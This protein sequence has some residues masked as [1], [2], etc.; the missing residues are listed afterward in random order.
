MFFNYLK[1]G[2][3]AIFKQKLFSAINV[4]GLSFS[5]SI[6]MVIIMLLADQYSY[7]RFNTNHDH[8][9]QVNIER[10][11]EPILKG[12]ATSPLP[13]GPKMKEEHSQ[14]LEYARFIRG[15]GNLHLFC[16]FNGNFFLSRI[17]RCFLFS[18]QLDAVCQLDNRFVSGLENL[19]FVGEFNS[20]FILKRIRNVF[21]F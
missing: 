19:H 7:D 14:V 5:L 1:T 17:N 10:F 6:C 12:M 20:D 9:Y 16:K 13:L 21:I 18:Y 15:F 3:R 8:I 2:L 4:F 11:D